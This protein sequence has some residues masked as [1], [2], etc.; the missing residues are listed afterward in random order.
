MQVPR[1]SIPTLHHLFCCVLACLLVA[2]ASGYAARSEPPL[3]PLPPPRPPPPHHLRS[4]G[5]PCPPRPLCSPALPR[6]SRA[7]PSRS[8]PLP[9]SRPAHHRDRQTCPARPAAQAP[10]P[11]SDSTPLP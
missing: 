10:D 8:D 11:R 9:R 2:P 7:P 4:A 1:A 6:L 5:E 3:R